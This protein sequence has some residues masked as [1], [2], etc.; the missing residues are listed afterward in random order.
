MGLAVDMSFGTHISG[1]DARA[2]AYTEIEIF[3]GPCSIGQPLHATVPLLNFAQRMLRPAHGL[4]NMFGC[5]GFLDEIVRGE[6]AI[7]ALRATEMG[8][9]ARLQDDLHARIRAGDTTPSQLGDIHRAIGG[10]Y[11]TA[12]AHKV[13]LSLI[14]A[15]SGVGTLIVWLVGYLASRL[16][17]QAA[18]HAAIQVEY[19]GAPPNPLDTGRV[20]Y[21]SALGTEAGRYFAS[22]VLGLP[23]ETIQDIEV[24]GVRIPQGTIVMHNTFSVNRDP[25]RY[26]RPDEFL[27]GRWCA[28]H[29]GRVGQKDPRVGVPHMNNGVGRRQCLGIPYVNKILY[30]TLI[31]LQVTTLLHVRARRDRRRRSQGSLPSIPCQWDRC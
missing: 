24:D 4:L 5:S 16:D 30:G 22:I 18:A 3:R 26:D 25:A 11:A 23:R 12:E 27:P 14:G 15:G 7:K 20:E 2:L 9:A 8:Y 10:S 6:D 29:Y 19:D 1:A 21:I 17:L 13:A 28:G 31:L